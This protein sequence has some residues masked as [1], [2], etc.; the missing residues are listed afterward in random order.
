M[1]ASF[2]KDF[3]VFRVGLGYEKNGQNCIQL[4]IILI[5]NLIDW[6]FHG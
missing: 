1:G 5:E 3:R 6:S 2:K 4:S